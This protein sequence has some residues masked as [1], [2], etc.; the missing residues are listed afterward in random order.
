VQT[1]NFRVV[2]SHIPPPDDDG[3]GR[4]NSDNYT[5][6]SGGDYKS[7][8]EYKSESDYDPSLTVQGV[9]AK[10][11]PPPTNH[12]ISMGVIESTFFRQRQGMLGKVGRGAAEI[13]RCEA[14]RMRTS[15]LDAALG[16]HKQGMPRLIAAAQKEVLST[17]ADAI[18]TIIADPRSDASQ[19]AKKHTAGILGNTLLYYTLDDQKDGR[20][21]TYAELCERIQPHLEGLWSSV[22]Q[23]FY[24]EE[25][26]GQLLGG[27]GIDRPPPK[28]P[29]RQDHHAGIYPPAEISS[30]GYRFYLLFL[31][32]AIDPLFQ[33]TVAKVVASFNGRIRPA[34]IKDAERMFKLHNTTHMTAAS[35]R[36]A[37][38][39]DVHG[40]CF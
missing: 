22:E 34:Q 35:P 16:V 1:V 15:H 39:V 37:L 13:A 8:G 3:A 18:G 4:Y 28:V 12:S 36:D 29:A 14:E 30:G 33:K 31:A 40:A 21:E 26:V 23:G 9:D 5:Y 7:G 11:L 17:L 2:Y 6:K 32:N 25:R 24:V 10:V 38:N 19:R 27:V 20:K